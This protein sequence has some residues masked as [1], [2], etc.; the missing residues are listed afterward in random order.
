M[1]EASIGLAPTPTSFAPGSMATP[2]VSTPLGHPQWGN[3][4]S[5]QVAGISQTLKNGLQTIEMRLDPRIW[6]PSAFH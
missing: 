2:L 4:F 6:A 1:T 5:Q 3:D